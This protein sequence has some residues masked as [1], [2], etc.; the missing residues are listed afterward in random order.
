MLCVCLFMK[1]QLMR[2]AS[3]PNENELIKK[4]EFLGTF[5]CFRDWTSGFSSRRV[6]ISF[7]FLD[8]VVVFVTGFFGKRRRERRKR[9]MVFCLFVSRETKMKN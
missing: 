7:D 8:F 9:N 3:P 6:S 2:K 1:K 5:L 4:A